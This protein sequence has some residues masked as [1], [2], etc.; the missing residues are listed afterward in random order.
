MKITRNKKLIKKYSISVFEKRNTDEAPINI[1]TPAPTAIPIPTEAPV[2]TYA[3]EGLIYL[4]SGNVLSSTDIGDGQY[5]CVISY[6]DSKNDYFFNKY[7]PDCSD[8]KYIVCKLDKSRLVNSNVTIV[9]Y[10]DSYRYKVKDNNTDR[11]SVV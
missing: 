1:E 3:P 2:P 8:V 10:V 4:T 6:C 9:I 7:F 11:K 5:E